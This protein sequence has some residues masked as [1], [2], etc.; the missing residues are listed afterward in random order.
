MFNVYEPVAKSAEVTAVVFDKPA[1]QSLML[2]AK[3]ETSTSRKL[4]FLLECA[5]PL[6]ARLRNGS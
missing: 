1:R 3:N 5:G 6:T 2:E 4:W